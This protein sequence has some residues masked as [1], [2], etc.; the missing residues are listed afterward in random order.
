MK[1]ESHNNLTIIIYERN[2]FC[3]V[4]WPRHNNN[5]FVLDI[6]SLL[7]LFLELDSK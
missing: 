4:I 3:I 2:I 7:H 6:D 5:F 1:N